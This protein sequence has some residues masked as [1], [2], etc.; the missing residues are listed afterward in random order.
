MPEPGETVQKTFLVV[1]V[2]L[3]TLANPLYAQQSDVT[4]FVIGKHTNF[5]QNNS[6]ELNSVDFSFFS[7]IFL[8]TDGDASDAYLTIPTRERIDFRDMRNADGGDRDN[9]FLVAGE[10]RYTSMAGLQTRYPDGEYRVSFSTPSGS[11]DSEVLRFENRGLPTPPAISLQQGDLKNCKSIAP[12]EDLVVSWGEF[13]EGKPDENGIL[14]DL[15]FVILTSEEGIRVSHSGRP[16]EGKPYL[17]YANSDFTIDNS[18]L[19][20][21]HTYSLSVEHAILDDTTRFDGVPAFTTRATTTKLEIRTLD[22]DAKQCS[23]QMPVPSISSQTTMFY[24]KNIDA[25]AKFYGEALGLEKTLDWP[26]VKFFATGPASTVG[27]VAEGEGA[28][29]KV[30]ESNAV[31]LSMVTEEVDAWYERLRERNDITFL[32]EIAD[33]GGIR[34]FLLEDPGGYT[35]EFFQWLEEAD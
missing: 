24:Y 9:I 32:K 30:Q 12:G 16:F 11:V 25:A 35:V 13:E 19:Q 18:V 10:D 20:P 34:S 6:G 7:E 26:W 27:I 1:F 4:F 28:W 22:A 14:D 33:G 2:P 15:V 21:N 8:T 29:H 31:M 3:I 17:T 23:L 5:S